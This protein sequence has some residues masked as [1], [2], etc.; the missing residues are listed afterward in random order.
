MLPF[1]DELLLQRLIRLVAEGG[2]SPVIVAAAS[3][4]DL[5]GLNG[6]VEV[7]RDPVDDRGPMA[8]VAAGLGAL[9]GRADWAYVSATDTPLLRPGWI[10]VLEG[11]ADGWDCVMP[12]VGDR[13]QPLSALYRV[14]I[15]S[16]AAHCLL[17]IGA[18]RLLG[19]ASRLRTRFVAEG[20]L[21]RVDPEFDSVRNLNSPSDY[22]STIRRLERRDG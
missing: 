18:D 7:V 9:V 1:G 16:A 11:L 3:G 17:A 21:A 4:Q 6:P 15:A 22:E 20:E 19:L 13:P 5:P 10:A 2:C 8:G 14:E 12:V